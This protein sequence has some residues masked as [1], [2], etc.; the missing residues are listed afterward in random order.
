[1]IE[2]KNENIIYEHE[3]RCVIGENEFNIS[4][5]PTLQTGPFG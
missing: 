1:M 5:N 2:F 4:Q 3:I